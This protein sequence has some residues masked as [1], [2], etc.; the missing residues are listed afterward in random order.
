MNIDLYTVQLATSTVTIVAGV[1]FILDTFLRRTDAAARVWAVSFMSG[2]LASFAYATWIVIPGAWWAVAVGNAAVVL[3]PALLWVGTRVYNGRRSLA[4]VGVV[5][6]VAAAIA[7]IVAGPNGGDWAGAPLMFFSVSVFAGLGAAESLSTPMRE[8]WMARGLTAVF[9]M[10]ALFYGA[11][12]AVFVARGPEDPVFDMFLGT[13]VS[14]FVLMSF[15]IVALVSLIVVQGDRMPRTSRPHEVTLSYN[16]D[17]VLNLHSL[18]EIVEDWLERAAF[19]DEQLVFMRVELDEIEALDA[20]FGRSVGAQL[21]TRF[22]E[23]VRRFSSPHSDIGV[24]APGAL[25]VVAPF[26]SMELAR[27]NAEEVQAG[28]RERPLEA[29]QNLRLSASI[30]LAGTDF[31]GY[32]FDRLMASAA[33]AAAEAVAQGGDSIVVAE[34]RPRERGRRAE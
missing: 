30:G 33:G 28:L 6:A 10:V 13:E 2:I 15:V 21:V 9:I 22:T 23:S 32:D 17:A 14:A 3:T 4:W 24:V 34:A 25:V 20:A 5:A 26:A 18:R 27:A 31:L 7:V 1:L 19:H 11:R 8:N 12:T 16:A 29:A